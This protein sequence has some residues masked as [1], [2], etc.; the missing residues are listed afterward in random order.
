M[1]FAYDLTGGSQ[2]KRAIP[3]YGAGTNIVQGAAIQRGTTDGTNEGYGVVGVST[4]NAFIGV[5]ESLFAAATLDNDPAAG[6]KYLLTDCTINPFGV[7]EC[8]YDQTTSLAVASTQAGTGITVTSGE[9]IGGGWLL[10]VAAP[11]TGY[12]A[13][14]DSSSSGAYTFKT[15]TYPFTT[16]SKVIKIMPLYAP[17]VALTTNASKIIGSTAGQGSWLIRVLENKVVAPGFDHQFLDP[18]KHDAL[19]FPTGFKLFA[20]INLEASIF[21]NAN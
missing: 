11:G 6:T 3:L 12:L 20:M 1:I 14:V 18:T 4:M 17:K 5:T 13:Y 8:E 15:T 2:L 19:T 21:L 9:S 10:G 16:A 7:W